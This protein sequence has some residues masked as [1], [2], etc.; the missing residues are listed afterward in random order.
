[1][2]ETTRRRFTLLLLAGTGLNLTAAATM[3]V[4]CVPEGRYRRL[5]ESAILK[6]TEALGFSAEDYDGF[7]REFQAVHH[8][9]RA[10][11]LLGFGWPIYRWSRIFERSADLRSKLENWE[12]RVTTTFLLSTNYF[13]PARD[14][15]PSYIGLYIPGLRP[16]QNPFA[17]RRAVDA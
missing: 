2:N 8:V 15:A 4:Y 17:R 11:Y 6:H 10:E 1:M 12:E 13:D 16:C 5:L 7:I 9:D 3:E 14:G